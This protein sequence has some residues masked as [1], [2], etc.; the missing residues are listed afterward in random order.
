MKIF[1]IFALV[2]LFFFMIACDDGVQ[3]FIPVDEIN[4]GSSDVIDDSDSTDTTPA[5]NDPADST[6]TVPSDDDPADSTDTVPGDDDPADSTDTTPDDDTD[7]S[8]TTPVDGDPTD[9]DPADDDP[10]DNDPTDNDPTPVDEDQIVIP[11]SDEAKCIAAGGHW[12]SSAVNCYVTVDCDDKPEYSEWNGDS[13]YKVYYDVNTE[14]WFPVAYPTQYGDGEPQ[15]C[16]YKCIE[17]YG[18][19]DG[20]CKPYCSAV[21]NGT[22]KSTI[23]VPAKIGNTTNAPLNLAS[24]TWTVEAWIKQPA[25]PSSENPFLSKGTPSSGLSSTPTQAYYL[26][27]YYKSG[28]KTYLKGSANYSWAT[29]ITNDQTVTGSGNKVSNSGNWTHVAMVQSKETSST[30]PFQQTTTYKLNLYI[31]GTS[32]DNQTISGI[33]SPTVAVVNGNLLIGT[34]GSQYFTGLIDS[35]RISS[36]AKYTNTF[37]P[38]KLSAESDTVAFWDFNGDAKSSVG[39]N[40][41]GT[42][43]A[44]TYSTD[45]K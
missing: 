3:R 32:V 8:D 21:F 7:S 14:T 19:E 44:V 35:I 33:G 29:N 26:T 28:T 27:G 22:N 12:D 6:D 41:D 5:D 37:T 24:E 34:S 16:Q 13:S 9:N 39:S 38:A 31:N 40:L 36:A 42:A 11:G 10:T 45:C 15:P 18:Y 1:R 23:E 4:D 20:E 2:S 30:N 25:T 17:K 43:T